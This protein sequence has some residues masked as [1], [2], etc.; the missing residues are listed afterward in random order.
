ME[1]GSCADAWIDNA[2]GSGGEL[3]Q[4]AQALAFLLRQRVI[5]QLDASDVAHS[6]L[7]K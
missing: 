1:R 7:Q 6:Y 5:T 2:C 3:Q 4:S